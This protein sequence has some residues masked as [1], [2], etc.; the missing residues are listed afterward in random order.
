[1]KDILKRQSV[2]CLTWIIDFCYSIVAISNN[3][4]RSQN[5]SPT[6][7]SARLS[8]KASRV[9]GLGGRSALSG[10]INEWP[11]RWVAWGGVWLRRGLLAAGSLE[12]RV[13]GSDWELAGPSGSER[14]RG[15]GGGEHATPMGPS[16]SGQPR[17]WVHDSD[18]IF[19]WLSYSLCPSS[20]QQQMPPVV[21]AIHFPHSCYAKCI[22][23]MQCL[24]EIKID[25]H[26]AQCE[27]F[28]HLH[29]SV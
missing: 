19:R 13:R 8:K 16:G 9:C 21:M 15:G 10:N 11:W 3:A 23:E 24:L 18:S 4:L 5:A 28:L 6:A 12:G 20:V 7:Q 17:G 1:M 26:S 2:L 22:A 29:E 14:P 27:L 25:V